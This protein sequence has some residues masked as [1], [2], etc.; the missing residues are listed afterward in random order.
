MAKLQRDL[1]VLWC[2]GMSGLLCASYLV[3]E[4]PVCTLLLLHEKVKLLILCFSGFKGSRSCVVLPKE[5]EQ[6]LNHSNAMHI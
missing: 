3:V 4:G 5:P 6:T 1:H 2:K